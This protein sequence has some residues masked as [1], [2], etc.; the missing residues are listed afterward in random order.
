M[1]QQNEISGTPG[2]GMV[3][4]GPRG[5]GVYRA[6]AIASGLTMYAKCGMLPNRAY[7]PRA[8]MRA[9]AE[10]TGQQFK[11]RDYVGAAAA[12]RAWAHAQSAIV[13]ADNAAREVAP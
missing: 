4:A 5:V 6:T 12:L 7:T 10:I 9:A 13:H 1:K 8:M 3:F 11:A 2:G